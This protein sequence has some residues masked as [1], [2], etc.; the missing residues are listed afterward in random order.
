MVNAHLVNAR[1]SYFMLPQTCEFFPA[2]AP[3]PRLQNPFKYTRKF[4][5]NQSQAG[6][7]AKNIAHYQWLD[8]YFLAL[9]AL[10]ET[11]KDL[12]YNT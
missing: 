6:A 2:F 4:R 10:N 5:I 9:L 12:C 11:V 3:I 8:W 7:P 1:L